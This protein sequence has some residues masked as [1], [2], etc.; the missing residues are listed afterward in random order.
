MFMCMIGVPGKVC[1]IISCVG[2]DRPGDSNANGARDA[3]TMHTSKAATEGVVRARACGMKG[4]DSN[5]NEWRDKQRD[6]RMAYAG[7]GCRRAMSV[8]VCVCVQ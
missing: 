8:R 4:P 2:D 5:E 3:A 7:R 6:R 1:G